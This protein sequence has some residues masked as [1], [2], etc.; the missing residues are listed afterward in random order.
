MS[1]T[2][3]LTETV[4][5][6]SPSFD[7]MDAY[8]NPQPGTETSADYPARLEALTSDELLRDRDTIVAD[9]RVFLPPAAVVS[10][11][12]RIEADGKSF[13]VHGDPIEQRAPRGIHHI[14]L[15]LKRVT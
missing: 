11:F 13:E 15:R 5:V 4:T 7:A 6:Y 1:L 12:A 8:G 3:M 14:E 2:G 9:W 10:P